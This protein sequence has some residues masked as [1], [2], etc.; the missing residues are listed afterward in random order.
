MNIKHITKNK[1]TMTVDTELLGLETFET[2][3]KDGA[4]VIIMIVKT[5]D[6]N[7]TNYIS[8]WNKNN[9]DEAELEELQPIRVTY[10][11]HIAKNNVEYKNFTKIEIFRN[12]LIEKGIKR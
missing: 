2:T 7:F 9:I 10:T 6:G 11:T 1:C 8:V 3:N 12:T 5:K 4:K